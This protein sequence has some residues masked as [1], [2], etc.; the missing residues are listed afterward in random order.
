LQIADCG[1][2]VSP[3]K[4]VMS[5]AELAEALA[6]HKAGDFDQAARLYR[7]ILDEDPSQP[8]VWNHLGEACLLRGR[9]A[10]AISSYQR[11]V[12]QSP[13]SAAAYNGLGVAFAQQNN[14]EE[15]ASRFRQATK[16]QP[17]DAAAYNNLGIALSNQGK[18]AQAERSYHEALRIKPDYAEALSNLGLVLG[19]LGKLPE[20]IARHQQALQIRA[21]FAAAH[22]NFRRAYA[23]HDQLGRELANFRLSNW[24]LSDDAAAY[25]ELGIALKSR[26]RLADAIAC[27]Q[28]SLRLRPD[29]PALNNLGITFQ[30]RGNLEEAEDCLRQAV[31]LK[32]NDPDAQN[33]LG[34]ILETTG[35]LE[36]AIK[37]YREALRAKP[38][39]AEPHNNLGNALSKLD[40]YAEAQAHYQRAIELRPD[41]I[42]AHHNLA[43]L[44]IDQGCVA[45]GIASY[46]HVLQL[47]PDYADAHFGRAHTWLRMGDFKRGW[48]EFEWRWWR[49]GFPPRSFTQPLW[50]G[51]PLTGRTILL[52]AEQ[53]LGDTIHFIRYAPLVKKR[54]GTVIVECQESLLPLLATC[55][56]IDY[57][58]AKDTPLPYFDTHAP[59]LSLPGILGTTLATIP[60][61]GPYLFADPKLVEL[62]RQTIGDT[63]PL[64]VGIAWQGNPAFPSD[65]RRSVPLTRFK[66]LARLEGV[67][68]FS[69]QKGP[70]TEQL[71]GA[72]GQLSI[73]DL[74]SRFQT[75]QDTAAALR[76]LDLVI[77]IDSAVA[78]CAG[79]LGVDGWVLLPYLA[80]WRWLSAGD[81]SPWY[82][83]L[84][85]F[86]QSKPGDWDGV[87]DRLADAVLARSSGKNTLMGGGQ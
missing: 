51:S 17:G 55:P 66:P 4:D 27:F 35:R 54:G 41:Y 52:H 73:I 43:G 78:H 49:K 80:D 38:H 23:V 77:T 47:K 36:E 18:L 79:A 62:W 63:G 60:A 87:F 56:G 31:A 69:V 61:E 74:G 30:E 81:D 13:E 65:R 85:L 39:F 42:E 71:T 76:V 53:G 86:R 34:A 72:A 58:V 33:N 57:L 64:K 25:N 1:L 59:L 6:S 75:F 3:S 48:P 14:W 50:D 24:H 26:G 29:F 22:D 70:G 46:E 40:E 45:E 7:Q 10:E 44:L 12:A 84:H 32:P 2:R 15:A 67:R 83:T 8:E 16:V 5:A 21:D 68:L 82:P 19:S 28:E 11:A 37:C 20:A 9:F